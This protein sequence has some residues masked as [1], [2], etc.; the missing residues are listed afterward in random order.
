MSTSAFQASH[1]YLDALLRGFRSGLL[2]AGDYANLSQAEVV[3]DLKVHLMNSDYNT[4]LQDVPSPL[5]TTSIA[6]ACTMKLVENFKH[7]RAQA[8]EPLATFMD[9]LSYSYMID[10]IV[11]IVSETLRERARGPAEGEARHNIIEKCHPLGLF[12]G[13]ASLCVAQTPAELY[14]LVLVNTPIAKYMLQALSMEDLDEMHVEFIRNLLYKEYLKDFY[15]YCTEEI[16]GETGEVMG[17]ILRFEAD[18]RAINIT[19]NSWHTELS[20]DER[21]K[22]YP[23]FGE[24]WPEGTQKLMAADD[25]DGVSAAIDYVESYRD[26]LRDLQENPNKSLEEAFMDYDVQ[27]CK[28]AF[29][30]HFQF[31]A[32]YAFF[33]LQ[34]QEIRNIIWI[35]DCIA[36]KKRDKIGNFTP[37]F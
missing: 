36:Q 33:R 3:D 22:L 30:R 19:V 12:E 2:S 11:L 37:I 14:H 24:L 8:V 13:M 31:G 7:I 20:K 27:L 18:R 1:G 9:F 15:R 5:V 28:L 25:M 32:I 21:Q 26:V 35:A 6:E 23:T 34:E 16:G 17:E 4:V 10:N 29:E